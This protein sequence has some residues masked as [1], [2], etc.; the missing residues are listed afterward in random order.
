MEK[1]RFQAQMR[2]YAK[3][4][5]AQLDFLIPEEAVSEKPLYESMRYSLLAGGKRV[6][7]VLVLGFV[8]CAAERKGRRS[9]LPARWR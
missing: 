2:E 6:R 5:N 4:V 7:P 3:L 8:R 9:H 1:T